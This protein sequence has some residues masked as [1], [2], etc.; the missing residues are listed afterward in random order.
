MAY[1]KSHRDQFQHDLYVFH[2]RNDTLFDCEK[3]DTEKIRTSIEHDITAMCY[4]QNDNFLICGTNV[5]MIFVL[6]CQLIVKTKGIM[7]TTHNWKL[8]KC[9]ATSHT[10]EICKISFSANCRYMATLD[11]KGEF[12]I[13]N[14][15]SWTYIFSYQKESSR[16][17][18]HFEWHPFVE[19]ELIFG[20]QYFP[21]LYL[22]NVSQR[23]IV[24]SFMNWKE[25]WEL[26]SIA[27]NPTTAQLAVCF[28][29]DGKIKTL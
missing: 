1:R 16:L 6:Q 25:N 10:N 5:G 17:Y 21:A 20:R 11:V 9:L 27:F 14:G 2:V 24:S 7:R 23:K 26:T 13:W 12:K 28:Y 22:F 19:N 29:N 4:T 15:G 3:L 18:K 8:H